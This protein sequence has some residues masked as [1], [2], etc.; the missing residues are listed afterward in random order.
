MRMLEAEEKELDKQ[1]SKLQEEEKA[2][3]FEYKKLVAKKD[4]LKYEEN[5]FWH[6]VNNYEKN[7]LNFEE[8][9]S[10]A[11]NLISNLDS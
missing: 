7:L 6:D 1:L 5:Y 10:Q 11:K 8:S 2:N 3:E 4:S 9:V